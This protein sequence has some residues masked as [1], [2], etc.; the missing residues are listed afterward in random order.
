MM[1]YKCSCA[2]R[3]TSHTRN[4]FRLCLVFTKKN[5]SVKKTTKNRQVKKTRQVK[6]ASKSGQV[7]QP[8]K[9]KQAK[10]ARL[11]AKRKQVKR[12]QASIAKRSSY[13][14]EQKKVVT[15]AEENGRNEAARHF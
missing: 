1:I 12:K 5:M 9:H 13:S 3:N 14:I 6:K 2:P 15:Y 11:A 10:K 4:L 8:A 7:K